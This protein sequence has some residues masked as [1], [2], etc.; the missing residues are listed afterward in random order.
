MNNDVN[1][2]KNEQL[3]LENYINNES[4]IQ[5]A[6]Q[7]NTEVLE[8]PVEVIPSMQEYE[9]DINNSFKRIEE[10]D[11]LKCTVIGVSDTGVTVDLALYAE[12]NIPIDEYSNNPS[13]SIIAD[14]S[15][16]E[17]INAMVIKLDDRNGNLLLSKKKADDVLAWDKLKEYLKNR[18]IVSVK[19]VGVVNA[20]VVTYL[21][22]IRAF[23]PASQ[24]SLSFVSDLNS[25]IGKEVEA[26]AITVDEKANKL[27]LSAKEVARDKASVDRT[28]K[29]SKLQKGIVTTGVIE[30][31]MPYGV[32]VNIGDGISG[33]VH[34]SEICNR[35]IASP[36]EV[37]KEGDEV[38]VKIIDVKDGKVSLSIKAVSENED[39][40]EEASSS[41][42][43]YTSPEEVTTGLSDLL[44]KFKF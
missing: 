3:E 30:S 38:N 7:E 17:I 33:L 22:G 23:I 20:G 36:K 42:S 15:I 16:G 41:L 18:T 44:S 4:R 6:E 24:L 32:F 5:E 39:V 2:V 10:G 34:I 21:E 9:D 13:F 14:V 8:V 19:I 35:R 25:W 11:I 37:V 29:I 43:E 40:L 26:I 1:V 31:L 27:V 28:S 12:G